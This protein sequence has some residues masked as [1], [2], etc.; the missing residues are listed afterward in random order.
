M[1]KIDKIS[2][3]NQKTNQKNIVTHTPHSFERKCERNPKHLYTQSRTH[4]NK[5]H[6]K[7]R[8][9]NISILSIAYTSCEHI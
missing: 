8:A 9:Q 1:T 4:T 2:E 5:W 6:Y 3:N 7:Q